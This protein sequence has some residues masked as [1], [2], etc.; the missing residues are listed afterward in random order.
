MTKASWGESLKPFVL[1]VA[2]LLIGT[3]ISQILTA[4]SHP[5]PR[6]ENGSNEAIADLPVASRTTPERR[7]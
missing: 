3:L 7:P 5:D 1:I 6:A 2:S 4:S